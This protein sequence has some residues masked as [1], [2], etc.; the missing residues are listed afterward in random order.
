RGDH[1]P[2]RLTDRTASAAAKMNQRRLNAI[3]AGIERRA[4]ENLHEFLLAEGK[5]SAQKRRAYAADRVAGDRLEVRSDPDVP[6][7]RLGRG[8]PAATAFVAYR[9]IERC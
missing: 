9:Q 4:E 2:D 1:E 3:F 6:S 7:P 5:V 8:D